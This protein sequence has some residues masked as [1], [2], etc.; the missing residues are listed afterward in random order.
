M[1]GRKS[2][3]KVLMIPFQLSFRFCLCEINCFKLSPTYYSIIYCVG[4]FYPLI[5]LEYLQD[6]ESYPYNMEAV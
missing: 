1:A 3:N 6:L 4:I 2:F 5:D